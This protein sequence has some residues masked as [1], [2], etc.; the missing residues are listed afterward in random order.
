MCWAHSD[1][2]RWR[3]WKG[4]IESLGEEKGV[5]VWPSKQR[6]SPKRV[7]TCFACFLGELWLNR[8]KYFILLVTSRHW[9]TDKLLFTESSPLCE[10]GMRKPSNRRHGLKCGA[11]YSFFNLKDF[12]EMRISHSFSW[13]IKPLYSC[14][15]PI[16]LVIKILQCTESKNC[17]WVFH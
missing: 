4:C 10:T 17:S 1:S 14:I 13:L 7:D 12:L 2:L 16:S 15:E 9:Q 11:M 6:I 5:S 8:C 3:W